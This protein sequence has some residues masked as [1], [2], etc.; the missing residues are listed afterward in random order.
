MLIVNPLVYL[1]NSVLTLDNLL[2]ENLAP[3]SFGAAV[4]HL[5][6]C[7]L[8]ARRLLTKDANLLEDLLQN[9][10]KTYSIAE[11]QQILSN[12][13]I[14]DE[15]SLK[16]ALRQLRQRVVLRIMFR[17]LNGF[18]DLDEVVSTTT[19]LAEVTLNVAVNFH[20]TWLE[21]S[22]G[23]PCNADGIAQSLIV[24]GM[25]KLGGA[26]LNVSSDID[27][28]FAYESEGETNSSEVIS[29]QEFF[30]K[31]AKKVISALDEVTA[32]G[33]V[34]R[35]DMRLRPFG[36]EGVL[37]SN[38]DALEDYYQNSGR[39]W[40][41]Y[42]WIKGRAVVGQGASIYALLRPFIFRKYL[43][44]NALNS[45]R[46]LKLQ[47][48]RDVTQKKQEDNIKLGRGGIR[49]I[50]FIAQVFQLI[51]GGQD[52]SL[53]IK[54]TLAVL[55][56]LKNK[57]LLLEKTV[58]ELIAA[59][60]FLRNL[61]HRLM[62]VEDAQTQELPKT[63]EA[64]ARIAKAM[65][66]ADWATLL[67]Q[68]NAHRKI[69][70]Q[71]FDA[72]FNEKT[73]AEIQPENLQAATWFDSIWQGT[74]TNEL[75]VQAIS[76]A[77]YSDASQT[78]NQLQMLRNSSRYLRLP[79]LSRQ[80]FD[81]LMPLV[82][83]QASLETNA[84][85]A[86]LRTINL[87]ENICGR[88][89]YLAL[90]AEFP[91]ALNLVIQ[92][93]AASPW[94]AQYLAAHPI[95]L[96]ELLDTQNLYAAPD[97][98]AMKQSLL[99][100]M[101]ELAGDTEAQMNAMRHFKHAAIM[102]FAAQD[103]AGRLTLETLSDYLST[104]ADVILQVSL[105]TIWQSLKFKHIEI[106]KFAVIGY[107]KLGSK[108]LGYVSDLDI[109]FLYDDNAPEASEIYARFAQRISSWFNTLTSAGLLYETDLQLRPDGNSGLLVS[110]VAAFREY[111]LQ[112]AWVWE[113]QALTRA[114][115]V[116][117]D[118]NIGKVFEAIRIE[119]ITQKRDTQ[120]LKTEVINMR[121]KMRAAQTFVANMFDIKHSVGGII[122][123]EF[124]VQYLVLAQAE[125]YSQL[126]GNIGNIGLLKLL[127]SLN[128]IDQNLAEK[129]V[130][131]YRDYRRLQHALKLQGAPHMRVEET[132]VSAHMTAVKALWRQVFAG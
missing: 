111:Q 77:G 18:A 98:V 43:D 85:A 103:I 121:E 79:E 15:N 16:K 25:G 55:K 52:A 70:A 27:L 17:D 125:K 123:V 60:V 122:D 64:K 56:F 50:E 80:R 120:K 108:E 72:T 29:N 58:E 92:L 100:K 19:N 89:S 59:Y 84:D 45:M 26:E 78:L 93:C 42:A 107:G 118:A 87:L 30:T 21:A 8:W 49:E 61:E 95:L 119:V 109:I 32:D 101:A 67:V 74:L 99:Q 130:L 22:F 112:K 90:L 57:G 39:E 48:H 83:K 66:Y 40:E 65:N 104:L 12:D 10:A 23:K 132:Q 35:V 5:C 41:R 33:F 53:Q 31:L 54:P 124:L 110:S 69:V 1:K 114:R 82:I 20:Q 116:A 86:L 11:M 81:A 105:P 47:I 71:Q 117:G 14:N 38:L 62:Y 106:P 96:D 28:I 37:V 68:L 36:S 88:A 24:I 97:F 63:D 102:R 129:V 75:A 2:L 115:F 126:T 4:A 7:S 6:D 127:A 9:H 51:R 3:A 113:H 76:D 131:A 128:I 91:Q 13:K 34:F 94:L 73:Q 46:D 44:F